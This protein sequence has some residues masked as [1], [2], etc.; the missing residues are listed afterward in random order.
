MDCYCRLL[1][2]SRGGKIAKTKIKNRQTRFGAH[3]ERKGSWQ[4]QT[5]EKP[6]LAKKPFLKHNS[7]PPFW[8][9]I[10]QSTA[11]STFSCCPSSGAAAQRAADCTIGVPLVLRGAGGGPTGGRAAGG[12]STAAS[13]ISSSKH[14]WRPRA[15]RG[16]VDGAGNDTWPR[17][18]GG[19]AAGGR[20][21]GGRDATA[22][23]YLLG[24]RYARRRAR[25]PRQPAGATGG[26]RRDGGRAGGGRTGRHGTAT[27]MASSAARLSP[28]GARRAAAA[29]HGPP[30]SSSRDEME[31]KT[32][33]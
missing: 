11:I 5:E 18:A 24:P 20:A 31:R 8:R 4:S 22:F 2:G 19:R 14:A 15:P 3:G 1:R 32:K 25:G 10:G 29:V 23:H 28:H 12:R 6:C 17:G 16:A 9:H 21:A 33:R 13:P 26:G 7:P 27:I 30:P